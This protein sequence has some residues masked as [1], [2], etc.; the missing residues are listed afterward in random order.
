MDCGQHKTLRGEGDGEDKGFV[1]DA[2]LGSEGAASLMTLK[3]VE[4]VAK[5]QV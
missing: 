1:R 4:L 3:D 2:L 5:R